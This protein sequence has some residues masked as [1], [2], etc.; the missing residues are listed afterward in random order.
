MSTLF[1]LPATWSFCVCRDKTSKWSIVPKGTEIFLSAGG[2]CSTEQP[3]TEK[4]NSVESR[5][6][7]PSSENHLS[8]PD[9]R[10]TA[11]AYSKIP[12]RGHESS[13]VSQTTEVLFEEERM[14]FRNILS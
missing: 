14:L 5:V 2:S 12:G 8:K 4:G 13:G 9:V 10:A 3:K 6:T 1:P 7:S 11:K